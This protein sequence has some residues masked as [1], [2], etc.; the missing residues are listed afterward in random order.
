MPAFYYK[1]RDGRGEALEGTLD[2]PSAD[3][4][5][6]QLQADGHTPVT[7]RQ[8]R[9]RSTPA[10]SGSAL[11]GLRWRRV[12]LPDL[13]MF[14]RQMYSL[15]RAGVPVLRAMDG[16]A[17]TARD[18]YMAQVIREVRNDL[19]EGRAMAEAL[20]KHPR[21]FSPLYVSIV[22]VGENAGRLDEAFLQLA[23]HLEQDKRTRDQVKA[24]M[25]Y[26]V[27]VLVAIAIAI[28]VINVFVIP[29]FARLFAGFGEQLPLPTRILLA[30]SE[31]TVS[32]GVW[33]LL[34]LAALVG[35]FMWWK[36]TPDGA[37]RWDRFKLRIPIVGD[38]VLRA[39]LAR[40]GRSFVM[41]SRS[42]VPIT[43]ALSLVARASGN[44]WVA[45]RIEGMRQA[46]ERG[47]GMAR[48][49]ANTELFTPLVMQMISVGEETGQM[50]D[51]MEQMADFYE[52]EVEY[53]IRQ[54]NTYIEPLLLVVV[55]VLVLILALGVFL[56]MWDLAQAAL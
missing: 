21:V 20:R 50:D 7:I 11:S 39:T 46:T 53:D 29:A 10:R 31:F 32:Y 45:S 8:T 16:L 24:A 1:A 4:V 28:A 23:N 38:I 55:G 42:G 30:T 33:L 44:A 15:N 52:Q 34:G 18:P 40:F 56:P 5:A 9:V 17:R 49:A 3:A 19:E 37:L 54:L 36:Q 26:P 12:S 6:E 35:L 47:E 25:R 51:M 48:S 43:T 27:M 41:A 13:I 2:A 22:Q 14:S